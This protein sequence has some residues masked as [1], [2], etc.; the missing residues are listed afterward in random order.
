MW[1][2]DGEEHV[3]GWAIRWTR[4]LALVELRDSRLFHHRAVAR[5]GGR[6]PPRMI[7][8]AW[9]GPA[10]CCQAVGVAFDCQ[11]V[12]TRGQGHGQRQQDRMD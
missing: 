10:R 12:A 2:E 9:A 4:D 6:A 7:M 11:R 5:V 8:T 1:G 3:P